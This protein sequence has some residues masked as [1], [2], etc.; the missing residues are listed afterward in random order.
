MADS[1]APLRRPACLYSVRALT[2]ASSGA[3]TNLKAWLD[4]EY[5][6]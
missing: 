2:G 5:L 1:A 6:S 3:I 4:V